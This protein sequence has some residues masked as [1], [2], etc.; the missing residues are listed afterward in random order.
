MGS[1]VLFLFYGSIVFFVIATVTRVYRSVNAPLH[2][3]WDLY[4]GS[5]VYEFTDW[6]TKT[7][8][9]LAQKLGTM[10]MDVLFL[11]EFYHRNRKFWYGLYAFH[12]GLYL[13]IL[14]HLW[15]FASSVVT[16]IETA[17]AFGWVWGTFATLLTF[18]GG[19]AILLMRITDEDLRVYYPPIH[20]AK[21]VFILL[22]LLG[23]MYAVDVHFKSSMPDLLKYVREQ[24]TFSDFEHK[25]HPAFGPALHVL[26]ASAWLVYLPFSHVFQLFFR[27]YHYLRWDEVANVRGGE[28]EARVKGLLDRPVTWSAAHISPGMRWKD[29]ASEQPPTSGTGSK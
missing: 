20:Y 17:S 11:R 25:L 4:K 6:W 21:W 7:H 29:V 8:S 9:P 14:W 24:V 1:V 12:A 5:S 22:T 2:V 19:A 3:H 23:G 28:V 10:I 26:F 13:L 16:D 27:Y 18:F 15:L